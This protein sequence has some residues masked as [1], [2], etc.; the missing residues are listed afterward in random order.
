LEKTL[1]PHGFH[2]GI[3]NQHCLFTATL[4]LH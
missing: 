2:V 3:E 1:L 4:P